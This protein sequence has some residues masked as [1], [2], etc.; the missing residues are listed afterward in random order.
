MK[1]SKMLLE[2]YKAWLAGTDDSGYVRDDGNGLCGNLGEYTWK[3]LWRSDF[4]EREE[5]EFWEVR[6][7]LEQE[8][9][10]QFI[11]AGLSAHFPFNYSFILYLDETLQKGCSINTARLQW[12]K[13]RISDMEEVK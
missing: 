6:E 4:T 10:L 11:S 12:V 8:M 2:F 13:D 1:S 3:H 9:K 5:G 7:K